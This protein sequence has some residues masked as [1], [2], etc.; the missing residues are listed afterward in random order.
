MPRNPT[1][2]TFASC[3]IDL[4]TTF[5]KK[6]DCSRDLAIFVI[7]FISSFEII[8][9]VIPDPYIW[10]LIAASVADVAAINCNGMKILLVNV[11]STFFVNGNP[12]LTNGPRNFRNSPFW[13]IIFFCSFFK[14]IPLFSKEL[15]KFILSVISFFISVIP[16]PAVDESP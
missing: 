2:C 6:L 9:V 10:F 11:V 4:L 16:E 7:S 13:L 8:S 14:N 1:V 5:I 15:M 3:S 12:D